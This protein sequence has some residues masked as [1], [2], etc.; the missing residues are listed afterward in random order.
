[1][2]G[3]R[4]PS[5]VEKRQPLGGGHEKPLPDGANGTGRKGVAMVRLRGGSRGGVSATP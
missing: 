2:G 1:M 5:V 3:K 4:D